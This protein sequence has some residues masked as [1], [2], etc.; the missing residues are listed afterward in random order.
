MIPV[1][2]KLRNPFLLSYPAISTNVTCAFLPIICLRYYAIIIAE[3]SANAET[4][5]R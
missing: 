2:Y 1:S 3:L 5:R 4:F